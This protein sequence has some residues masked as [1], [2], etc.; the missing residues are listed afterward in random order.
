MN[1]R[2]TAAV[3]FK[4]CPAYLDVTLNHWSFTTYPSEPFLTCVE[5]ETLHERENLGVFLKVL[6]DKILVGWGG[7]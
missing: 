7:D 4:Q 2:L 1:G 6:E 5:A 3:D